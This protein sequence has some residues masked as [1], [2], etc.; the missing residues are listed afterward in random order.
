MYTANVYNS[1]F[2]YKLFNRRCNW[3]SKHNIIMNNKYID[4]GL[5]YWACKKCS[6]IYFLKGE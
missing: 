4:W 6:S 1:L 5:S 3:F 2:G